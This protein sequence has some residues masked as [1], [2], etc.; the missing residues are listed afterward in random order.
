MYILLTW[1]FQYCHDLDLDEIR[2][3]RKD[4]TKKHKHY[5][6]VL[7]LNAKFVAVYYNNNNNDDND[8]DE[9]MSLRKIAS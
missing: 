5:Y 7:S 1:R 6:I 3:I 2:L 4:Y 8:D 9:T